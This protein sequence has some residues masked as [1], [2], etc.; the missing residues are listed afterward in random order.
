MNRI[1]E[2][3]F[4]K[5][6]AVIF[7][8]ISHIGVFGN[9]TVKNLIHYKKFKFNINLKIGET[10]MFHYI[11]VISHIIFI[12]LVGVNM[13]SSYHKSLEYKE[14]NKE[15]PYSSFRKRNQRR[16][17]IILVYGLV[18]SLLAR[19]FF[20]KWY[21]LFGI[22]QFIGVSILIAVYFVEDYNIYKIILALIFILIASS[23]KLSNSSTLYN[24]LIGKT[25]DKF[26]DYF[27]LIPYFAYVLVGIVAGK[28]MYKKINLFNDTFKYSSLNTIAK[29]GQKALPIYFGHLI[30]LFIVVRL[31]VRKPVIHI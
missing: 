23:V 29:I 5:G 11:G 10:N 28:C 26:M 19:I 22:F 14:T 24:F 31:C 20:G 7:M 15:T 27:P 3:D 21:I 9:I 1:I 6:L 18:M 12:I 25:K 16:A 4:F 17:L 8:M 2:I 13:V 30:I